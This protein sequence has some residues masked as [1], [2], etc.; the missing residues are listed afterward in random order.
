[1]TFAYKGLEK[2]RGDLHYRGEESSTRFKV[3][4]T[5]TFLGIYCGTGAHG[6]G[7]PGM[8]N[9]RSG[10]LGH[11]DSGIRGNS[12]PNSKKISLRDSKSTKLHYLFRKLPL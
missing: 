10:E 4:E 8:G 12:P 3:C 1:M 7:E 11:G 6:A 9:W 5:F 2:E